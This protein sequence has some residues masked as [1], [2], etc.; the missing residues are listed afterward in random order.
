MTTPRFQPLPRCHA[1]RDTLR[2]MK[3]D[4][5]TIYTKAVLTVIAALL[6]INVIANLRVPT[7]HAQPTRLKLAAV[8]YT[9]Y[10][11]EREVFGTCATSS[12]G[13]CYVLQHP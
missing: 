12:P 2:R 6:A 13:V 11:S 10:N 3:P 8:P 5:Y 1:R 4:L 7:V 9:Q